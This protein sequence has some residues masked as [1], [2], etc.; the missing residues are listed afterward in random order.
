MIGIPSSFAAISWTL[1]SGRNPNSPGIQAIFPALLWTS[2]ATAL[3]FHLISTFSGGGLISFGIPIGLGFT[4]NL[5]SALSISSDLAP[6][7]FP[8][9]GLFSVLGRR[10]RLRRPRRRLALSSSLNS[11]A[12]CRSPM[13]PPCQ[14]L[15]PHT[16]V[17]VVEVI[18]D[19]PW[20]QH[21][22][23]CQWPRKTKFPT[24]PPD[25]RTLRK[26][27]SSFRNEENRVEAFEPLWNRP[28]NFQAIGTILSNQLYP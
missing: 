19:W 12:R 27:V 2:L 6:V 15:L 16:G 28:H 1:S 11:N 9:R 4:V 25:G 20:N 23:R 24:Y 10:R 14:G 17:E 18:T 21:D 7:P 26:P 22:R 5:A 13:N 3:V 8:C